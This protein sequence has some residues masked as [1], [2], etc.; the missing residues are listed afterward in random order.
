MKKTSDQKDAQYQ[1]KNRQTGSL[2]PRCEKIHELG[3]DSIDIPPPCRS[4][5]DDLQRET[6]NTSQDLLLTT[7]AAMVDWLE[8]ADRE[9]EAKGPR[10][11]AIDTEA[12]SLHCYNEKLS[13]IQIQAG[14]RAILIDPLAIDDLTPL[15]R[16]LDTTETWLHGMDYDLSLFQS[17][18]DWTP[19]DAKDTQIA[20]QLAGFRRFGLASLHEEV[21]DVKMS[22][23]S[24]RADWSMRPLTEEMIHYALGDVDRLLELADHLLQQ[25]E[26]KDRVGWFIQS[27][28]ASKRSVLG[29]PPKDREDSWRVKGFG[30]LSREGWAYLREIWW[31]REH[32]AE[33]L[34]R[35]AF[36]VLPNGKM[37]FLID[38]ILDGKTGDLRGRY[39]QAQ[40]KRFAEAVERAT[41]LP[42]SEWPVKRRLGGVRKPEDLDENV[43]RIKAPRDR[44]AE[45]LDLDPSLIV[46]RGGMEEIVMNP[47]AGWAALLPWQRSILE[48]A[49]REDS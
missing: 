17:T 43:A 31:W 18:F 9:L 10:R 36:K 25:L 30:R 41:N 34:N 15:F 48:K 39:N 28:I 47:E 45:R 2:E 24:Q 13:L 32:E 44:L 7:R 16:F 12:D 4:L 23:E 29:R 11:V 8:E 49:I 20:A 46:T 26:Q 1:N 21:F 5:A 37:F 35:P 40:K 6:P 14:T 3:K 19:P 27:C 22:K 38:R 42:K 33:R